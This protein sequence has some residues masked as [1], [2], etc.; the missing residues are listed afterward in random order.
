MSVPDD[1]PMQNKL[2]TEVYI[3]WD[4]CDIVFDIPYLYYS[5]MWSVTF[6]PLRLRGLNISTSRN[7]RL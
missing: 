6:L 3:I 5:G 1:R 7:S 2:D 4:H